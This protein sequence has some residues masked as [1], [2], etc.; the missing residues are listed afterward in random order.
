MMAWG[1]GYGMLRQAGSGKLCVSAVQ[2]KLAAKV[3]KMYVVLILSVVCY[4]ASF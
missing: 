1:E 3:A 2:S 4:F